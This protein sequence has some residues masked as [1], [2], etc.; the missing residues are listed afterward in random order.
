M[1]ITFAMNE[2][3]YRRY[4]CPDG[5]MKPQ[6]KLDLKS[7]KGELNHYRGTSL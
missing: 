5:K 2:K 3:N 1:H 6:M 4:A 7:C